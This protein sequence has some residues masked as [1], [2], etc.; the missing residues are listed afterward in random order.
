MD[1]EERL[2]VLLEARIRDFEKNMQRASGTGT[3]SYNELRSGSSRA[4]RQM[5]TDMV[6][7]TSRINQALAASS[8]KIGSYGK[9][10]AGGVIG[11]FT[12]GGIAGI[13]KAAGEFAKSIAS[14]GDEAHRAGLSTTA[15]QELA[16]VAKVNRI[17]VDALT[18]GM[19][20]LSLRADE[21]IVTGKGSGADAFQRLGYSASDLATKLKDPSALFTEIIGKLGK[22]DK[23]AQIRIADELFGGTG[24][25]KFV[26][27]IEQG[28]AGIRSQIQAAHDLGA[29]LDQEVI[30]RAAEIDKMFGA[31]STTI[32]G[33]VQPKV[34]SFLSDVLSL[35][36]RIKPAVGQMN[37][38]LNADLAIYGKR[39]LEIENEIMD[40]QARK[41]NG[42]VG[43]GD[44]YF[45]TGVGE[46]TIGERI[47][48]LQREKEALDE[49]ERRI[50][51]VVKARQAEND[52]MA[53]KGS[54]GGPSSAVPFTSL[55]PDDM[56]KRYQLQAARE[57]IAKQES[58]GSG[59]YK[60]LGPVTDTGDRAYGRYQVMGANIG[61]WSKQALGTRLTKDQ[62]LNNPEYQ[63]RIFDHIFGGYLDKFGMEG[64]AQAW[65]GG[66]GSVGKTGRKDV[67]GTSVGQYGKSFVD[68][69]KDRWEGLREVQADTS[70]LEAQQKAYEDLGQIGATALQGLADALADGKLEGKEVLQ[71]L[72]RMIE[73]L[74]SM[75]QVQQGI[76]NFFSNLLGSLGGGGSAVSDP[77]AG[78][79]LPGFATGTNFAPGGISRI[80]ERG[81]EIVDLPR[82]SRVIPHDISMAMARSQRAP[83]FKSE[84]HIHN[85]A[86]AEISKEES[87]DGQGGM[88]TDIYIDRVVAKRAGMPGSGIDKA[89]R[90][91]GAQ[92]PRV[93]R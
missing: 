5:E 83:Q 32:S 11:G 56:T 61:N 22:L 28:E 4:T 43:I 35:L 72:V 31:I 57:Q 46:T 86:G 30:Q 13:T 17:E 3:R 48:E 64:A 27:L 60:A 76:G 82:G 66:A 91:R 9:A 68:G 26:Q 16:Y 36:D 92:L 67:L 63:D 70:G 20:E 23:A 37:S 45:G 49:N 44:G 18:D 7:S 75:P 34:I 6:R 8:A 19:K 79:R 85:N 29:V 62:F 77:W 24:G 73:Q 58:A 74:L 47:Q 39:R 33:W 80:N 71:I 78:L 88:R 38:T 89:L 93:R 52:A 81:G 65:F 14:V 21:F 59:G 55:P 12:A 90:G 51:A 41:A 1:G 10:F 54:D 15:F 25:E 53:S 42:E 84:T 40:L 2:V 87:D 50:M 69:M